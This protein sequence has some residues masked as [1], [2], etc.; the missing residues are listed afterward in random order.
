MSGTFKALLGRPP[1]IL[2]MF[3][4]LLDSIC[5]KPATV[6]VTQKVTS[7]SEDDSFKMASDMAGEQKLIPNQPDVMESE[8]MSQVAM[9]NEEGQ[10]VTPIFASDSK[11][12]EMDITSHDINDLRT[13]VDVMPSEKTEVLSSAQCNPDEE[14]AIAFLKEYSQKLE[15]LWTESSVASW[16]YQTN[17]TEENSLLAGIIG[18]KVRFSLAHMKWESQCVWIFQPAF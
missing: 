7:E 15:V 3:L 14:E 8:I 11:V 12:S 4:L 17:T 16:N 5:A 1:L 13:R 10:K 2:L 18:G 6:D 9:P